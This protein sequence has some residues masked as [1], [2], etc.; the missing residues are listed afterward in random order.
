MVEEARGKLA[1]TQKKCE[2]LTLQLELKDKSMQESMERE[3]KALATVEKELEAVEAELNANDEAALTE[4]VAALKAQYESNRRLLKEWD[5][6][7]DSSIYS[8]DMGGERETLTPAKI[9][10]MDFDSFFKNPNDFPQLKLPSAKPT[11]PKAASSVKLGTKP[12]FLVSPEQQKASF[13]SVLKKTPKEQLLQQMRKQGSPKIPVKHGRISSPAAVELAKRVTRRST[14]LP[15]VRKPEAQTSDGGL[16]PEPEEVVVK[17]R[18]LTYDQDEVDDDHPKLNTSEGS[19]VDVGEEDA[20]MLDEASGEDA[21]MLE[22]A[23][24]EDAAM[25]DE[26]RASVQANE[27][28][29][30]GVSEDNG[31]VYLCNY[32]EEAFTNNFISRRFQKNRHLSRQR[33]ANPRC[34]ATALR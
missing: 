18:A 10:E 24:G 14:P 17:P 26:A 3:L 19:K 29:M 4:E 21:A 16:Q 25:L 2:E 8:D 13:A 1:Q 32:S 33:A 9:P 11:P 30:E 28:P 23:S 31:Q 7:D 20:E 15:P 6:D 34:S 22:E 5:N 27:A 12:K